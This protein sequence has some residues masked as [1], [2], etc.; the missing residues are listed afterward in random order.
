MIRRH[1]PLA[2]RRSRLERASDWLR[3]LFVTAP[4]L[5]AWFAVAG[6]AHLWARLRAPVH[7]TRPAD[8]EAGG[9]GLPVLVAA[10]VWAR[11][12]VPVTEHDDP[13]VDRR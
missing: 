4:Q 13:A 10:E 9:I 11:P 5:A 2:R 8:E 3:L 6:F 1:L 7:R 12:G